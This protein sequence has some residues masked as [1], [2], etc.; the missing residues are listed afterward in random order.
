MIKGPASRDLAAA[1]GFGQQAQSPL[2]SSLR[3]P[4]GRPSQLVPEMAKSL[5]AA[6]TQMGEVSTAK[7][8]ASCAGA[9]G[10]LGT[11]ARLDQPSARMERPSKPIGIVYWSVVTLL[12]TLLD[13]DQRTPFS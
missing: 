3:G 1:H 7:S 2:T 9:V 10:R 5:R 13:C 6:A 8:D 11:P 4:A 12:D